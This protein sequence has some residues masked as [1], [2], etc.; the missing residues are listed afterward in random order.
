MNYAKEF[1]KYVSRNILGMVGLSCYILADTFFVSKALGMQGL[2]ALN[3][4]IPIYNIIHGC[5]LMIGIGSSTLYSI[6]KGKGK[7]QQG[8]ESFTR[9]LISVLVLSGI[10][11]LLGIFFYE[12]I[13]VAI[14]GQGAV[15]DMTKV[16]IR[17]MLIFA[18]SYMLN[19]LFLCFV[20]NDGRPGLAM[21]GML[22]S[23]FTNIFLD[24]VFMYQLDMG[25]FGAVFATGL[26]P[27]VSIGL[28]CLY[29][30]SKKC[31]YGLTAIKEVNGKMWGIGFPSFV[32]EASIGIVMVLF[33][34]V[35]LK[36]AGEVGVAA[37]G[38]I[39]NVSLVMVSIFTG[40][41][42]GVQPLISLAYG[43]GE[44]QGVT[45]FLRQG[46]M[47]T[48]LLSVVGYAL[49][50]WQKEGIIAVFNS[51]CNQGLAQMAKE[52][53]DIY[54]LNLPFAGLCLLLAMY[55]SCIGKTRQAQIISLGRG[56]VLVIPMLF[57]LSYFWGMTG[58][59]LVY[60]ITEFVMFL[61]AYGLKIV[62]K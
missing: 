14:G 27:L 28:T 24:Y 56:F 62:V 8:R 47:A 1:I 54:F 15:L 60:P 25:I 33:N 30:F 41:A 19:D 17:V 12:Q 61:V 46:I 42:Q 11:I 58:V 52:G 39:A 21:A 31:G 38:V 44:T 20:R 5:G 40:L 32:A 34:V 26:S 9:G 45:A 53:I 37:Y 35:I 18:P 43:K 49:I 2:A 57:F 10:F 51:E 48:M 29:M 13:A 3:I 16:Y 6:A 23:S 4:A 36:L 7:L 59:W 22:A 50:F 55:F